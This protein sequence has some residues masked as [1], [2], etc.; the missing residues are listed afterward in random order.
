MPA[1]TGPA[2][3]TRHLELSGSTTG[4]GSTRSRAE[5]DAWV[6]GAAAKVTG[7][8]WAGAERELAHISWQGLREGEVGT[9]APRECRLVLEEGEPILSADTVHAA[10][11][12]VAAVTALLS[13]GSGSLHTPLAK[14]VTHV[15]SSCRLGAELLLLAGFSHIAVTTFLLAADT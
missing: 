2:G 3:E 5:S 12:A 11:T 1:D 8:T 13:C 10:A 7:S 15:L 4:G 14:V 9:E 6:V